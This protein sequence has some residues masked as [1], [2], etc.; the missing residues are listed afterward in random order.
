M[1]GQNTLLVI[2]DDAQV[3]RPTDKW[4]WQVYRDT[5][6]AGSGTYKAMNFAGIVEIIGGPGG[7]VFI[8][9]YIYAFTKET[10]QLISA[11]DDVDFLTT[12]PSNGITH[13]T[14]E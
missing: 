12:G 8:P 7:N 14:D 9:S 4:N 11:G 5:A 13:N 1:S 3:K 6:V 2:A 10:V